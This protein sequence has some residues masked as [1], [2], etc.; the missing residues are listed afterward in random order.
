MRISFLR[1]GPLPKRCAFI[2]AMGTALLLSQFAAAQTQAER[3]WLAGRYDWNRI[4]VYFDTVQF[5]GTVP[6]EAKKIPCPIQVGMFCPVELPASYIAQFQKTRDAE[7]F[8]V[9]DK[10]DLILDS[11]SIVPITLTTLVGF[12]SDEE[13]GNESFIGALATADKDKESWLYFMNDYRVVRR[14][15]ELSG[16]ER[17]QAKYRTVV[18]SLSDEPVEFQTQARVVSLLKD[19]LKSDVSPSQAQEAEPVSP[20]FAIQQFRL[21]DGSLRYYARAGWK[22]GEGRKAKLICGL[23]AFIAPQPTLHVLAID[24]RPGFEYLPE[25]LKVIEIGPGKTGIIISEHQDDGGSIELLEYQ[26]G[27]D[28]AHMH[29]LQSLGAGE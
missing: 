19:S 7:H 5:N 23:S 12:Q 10:Y 11:G 20:L 21:P 1:L 13:V 3:Y 14:H 15:R 18:A 24:S 6:P 26:D 16:E 2:L 28:L 17:T 9:G 22:S 25:L 8:A 27:A 4:I 29:V